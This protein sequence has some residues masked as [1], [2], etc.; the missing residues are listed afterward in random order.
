[1]REEAVNEAGQS[2]EMTQV[3]MPILRG[4]TALV[5]GTTSGLGARFARVLAAAGA[6][7]ALTGRRV[8]RLSAL[9]TEITAAGGRVASFALDITSEDSIASVVAGVE[10]ALGPIDI[11]VN[12]AGMNVPA[13]AIDL[14]AEDFDQIMSTNVR[15]AF[16]TARTVARGMIARG[17]GGRIIT[18]TSI[19]AQRVLPGLTAYCMSKAAVAMMTQSLA[20]EWARHDINVTA[21]APGYIETEIN[22]D[23]FASEGGQ[24]QVQGFPRRRLGEMADLDGTLLLLASDQS[25][26]ITGTTITVDDG[27][28]L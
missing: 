26:I 24:R 13:P 2:P 10:Q 17:S 9:E 5:T 22:A 19:G 8:E 20:R 6:S 27:Q 23:W 3:G 7:V 18:I 16:L 4:R 28:S 21:I 11:L 14:T 15:G 25:R 12:N 1:M